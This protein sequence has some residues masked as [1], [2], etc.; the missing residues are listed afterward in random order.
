LRQIL[1]LAAL[2]NR[3]LNWIGRIKIIEFYRYDE[4]F[5]SGAQQGEKR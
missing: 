4:A 1:S 3:R 2:K 5:F